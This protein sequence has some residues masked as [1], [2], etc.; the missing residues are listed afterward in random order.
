VARRGTAPIPSSHFAL[1]TNSA[2]GRPPR[3]GGQ[4]LNL[5]LQ[6]AANL[7]W[8]LAATVR[9]WAPDGL[10]DSYHTERSVVALEVIDDSLAQCALFANPSREGRALRDRFNDLLGTHP[11]LCGELAVRLSGLGVRY[12]DDGYSGRLDVVT[13]ELADSRPGWTDVRAM[14]IRPDGHLAWVLRDG[15]PA[16]ADAPPLAAWLGPPA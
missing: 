2:C 12:G 4:G 7:G 10:L 15:D 14:L 8:K 5:G 11:E 16:E 13:A 6:D 1:L 3:P 9:G